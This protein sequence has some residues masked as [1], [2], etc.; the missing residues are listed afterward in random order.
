MISSD[1]NKVTKQQLI[2]SLQRKHFKEITIYEPLNA[3]VL[4]TIKKLKKDEKGTVVIL[5]SAR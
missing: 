1:P 5:R 2:S 4:E 3:E